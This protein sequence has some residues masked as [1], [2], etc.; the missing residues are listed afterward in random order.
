M[1]EN[2]N[3]IEKM[4][5]WYVLSEYMGWASANGHCVSRLPEAH[6]KQMA[7]ECHG[8]SNYGRSLLNFLDILPV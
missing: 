1:F 2:Y 5:S 8:L 4:Q 3:R 7:S 6:D